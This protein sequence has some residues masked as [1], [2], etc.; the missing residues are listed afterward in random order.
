[1]DHGISIGPV[2]GLT[3]ID[4]TVSQ[5]AKGGADAVVVH[6]GLA[7][8]VAPLA[9]ECE[10]VVHLSASTDMAPDPNRKELVAT[11]EFAARLGASAVSTHVN[12]GSSDEAMMLKDLGAAAEACELLGHA[13]L[14]H[15]VRERRRQ[16]ERVRSEKSGP[17]GQ[18]RRRAGRGHRQGQLHR[19]HRIVRS[20]W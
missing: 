13:S 19:K 12:L 7:R 18:G 8:Y 3:G 20:T 16:R 4:R 1:M 6:K 10:M 14:G 15:D 9:K 2:T 17:R 11:P 5:V